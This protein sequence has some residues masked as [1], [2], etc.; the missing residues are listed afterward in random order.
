LTTR[1]RADL[2]RMVGDYRHCCADANGVV[3][4]WRLKLIARV[5]KILASIE[6]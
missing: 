5:Q 1:Q 6:A 4:T 3:D 2:Y